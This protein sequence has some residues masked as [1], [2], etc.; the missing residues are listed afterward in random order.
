MDK[1]LKWLIRS[2]IDPLLCNKGLSVPCA[3]GCGEIMNNSHILQCFVINPIEQLSLQKRI[4]ENIYEMKK[5]L[6]QWKNNINKFEKITPQDSSYYSIVSFCH[7]GR[8]GGYIL[9]RL[10]IQEGGD[11]AYSDTG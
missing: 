7:A 11:W 1:S 6:D 10:T 4:N 5:T 3:T 2:Q 8:G 9:T